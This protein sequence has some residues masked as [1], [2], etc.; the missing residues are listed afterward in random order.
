MES[1]RE[2]ERANESRSETKEMEGC[3]LLLR[4]RGRCA[5]RRRLKGSRVCVDEG[6][7]D[8]VD[9]SELNKIATVFTS[10]FRLRRPVGGGF[11][12]FLIFNFMSNKFLINLNL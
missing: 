5:K 1:E 11:P 9:Q 7:F 12:G 8:F 10:A 2:R 3:A 4:L 6:A